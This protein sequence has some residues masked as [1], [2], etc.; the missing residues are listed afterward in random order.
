M[1]YLDQI[2]L[3]KSYKI[4]EI[5]ADASL[6]RRFLDIGIIPGA[7]IEKVLQNPFGGISGYSI[8][9]STFAIRDQDAK[10]IIVYEEL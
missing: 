6:K 4:K 7:S 8:M 5:K 10:G 9:G 1:I 2:L 3:D